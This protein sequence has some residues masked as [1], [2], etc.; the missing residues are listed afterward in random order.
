VSDG[1]WGVAMA[2]H[3]KMNI[4]HQICAL[5]NICQDLDVTTQLQV[6]CPHI[7]CQRAEMM[8]MTLHDGKMT[9]DDV[10]TQCVE[11]IHDDVRKTQRDAMRTHA[12]LLLVKMTFLYV[13]CCCSA[14][15]KTFCENLC[16]EMQLCD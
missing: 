8:R 3:G 9:D 4:C 1:V 2:S 12:S 11:M 13:C 5:Q 14:V 10:M 7:F 15:E 6:F 16:Q